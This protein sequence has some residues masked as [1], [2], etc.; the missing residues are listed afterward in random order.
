MINNFI[1]SVIFK[2]FTVDFIKPFDMI[3]QIAKYFKERAK[4]L[5][6]LFNIVSKVIVVVLF[7]TISIALVCSFAIIEY[8]Y[9]IMRVFFSAM[10]IWRGLHI[11]LDSSFFVNLLNTVES[12]AYFAD[13]I[14][15][16]HLADS[17]RF[18]FSNILRGF[19]FFADIRIDLSNV[20]VQLSFF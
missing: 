19:N 2:I 13:F 9:I 14:P 17:V 15:N 4:N 8:F 16:L 7:I 11:S 20:Q 1:F 12:L 18:I 10:I 5:V 3:S 6:R